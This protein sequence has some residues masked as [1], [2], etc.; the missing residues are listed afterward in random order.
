MIFRGRRR[1]RRIGY[2]A[3]TRSVGAA[4]WEFLHPFTVQEEYAAVGKPAPGALDIMGDAVSDAA[5]AG[6]E[7]VTNIGAGALDVVRFLGIAA[8]VVLVMYL[9]GDRK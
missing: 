2:T 4:A 5:T 6:S 7:S 1:G 3:D 9:F 8:G